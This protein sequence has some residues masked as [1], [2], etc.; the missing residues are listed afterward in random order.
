MS[1]KVNAK[2]KKDLINRVVVLTLL[3]IVLIFAVIYIISLNLSLGWFSNN[4]GVTAEGMAVVSET[5]K[6][7]LLVDRTNEYDSLLPGSVP[8]YDVIPDFKSDLADSG[9]Y[10]F[11]ENSTQNAAGVANELIN[12]LTYSDGGEHYRFLMPGSCGTM[13]FYLKPKNDEAVVANLNISIDCFEQVLNGLEYTYQKT[14]NQRVLDFLKG[15][16]LLFEE[17]TGADVEHYKYD[18]LI[19]T[20]VITYDTSEH[21]KCTVPGKTD[22]YMLTFYWEWPPIYS[23]MS[24]QISETR[25]QKKYPP[26]LA[27]YIDDNRGYFFALNQ[28]SSD[29]QDLDDGYN[30]ADQIIGEHAKVVGVSVR[31]N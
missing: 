5:D 10:S 28:N 20:G 16:I 6:F 2:Q 19:T 8:K 9:A 12:E 29:I 1:F 23:A 14:E 17:R 4:N 13:T 7:Y 18:G 31:L 3:F 30:D 22:C 27:D 11:T 21:T 15:H 24:T 26:E 25:G